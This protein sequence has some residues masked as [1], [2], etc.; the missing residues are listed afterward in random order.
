[1]DNNILNS[2]YEPRDFETKIYEDWEEKGYFKPSNDK[3]MNLFV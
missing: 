1:M 3:K 2:K